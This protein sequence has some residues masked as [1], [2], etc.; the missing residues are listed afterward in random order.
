MET[1]GS[2]PR[3]TKFEGGKEQSNDNHPKRNREMTE[4]NDQSSS[5]RNQHDEKMK[6]DEDSSDSETDF[7]NQMLKVGKAAFF[8]V[9]SKDGFI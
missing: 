5:T 7:E 3:E 9:H 1:S 4:R 8:S 2:I 6:L